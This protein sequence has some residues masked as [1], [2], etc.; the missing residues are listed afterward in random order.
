MQIRLA[1]I[2]GVI[3]S[4]NAGPYEL[5]FDI[6]FRT[7][8]WFDTI[9]AAG[10][11]DQSLVCRLYPIDPADLIKIV[12]FQP[13]NA[14]KITIKR[15]VCSGDLEDTDIYGAQQHAPWLNAVLDIPEEYCALL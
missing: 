8:A 5:T 1:D 2:A 9:M 13:A 3:R 6:L 14:Y 15:P 11:L 10:V 4:K 7:T 12:A